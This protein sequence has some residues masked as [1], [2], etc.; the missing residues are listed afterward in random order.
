MQKTRTGINICQHC[1]ASMA[2]NHRC[3]KF[4]FTF[5]VCRSCRKWNRK[6]TDNRLNTRG[7]N[8]ERQT[9]FDIPKYLSLD[10][11]KLGLLPRLLDRL[12]DLLRTEGGGDHDPLC[13]YVYLDLLN[14]LVC[15]SSGKERKSGYILVRNG[16]NMQTCKI[17]GTRSSPFK[18]PSTRSTAPEHPSQVMATSNSKT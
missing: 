5:T 12:K 9:E 10:P 4:H 8:A 17:T 18:R 11:N 15:P 1:Q 2:S 6:L 13:G 7:A 14:A 3:I 16:L